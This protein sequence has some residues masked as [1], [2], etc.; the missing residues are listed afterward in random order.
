MIKMG[1][2]RA[3]IYIDGFNLYYGLKEKEWTKYYGWT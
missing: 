2:K 3:I 1:K